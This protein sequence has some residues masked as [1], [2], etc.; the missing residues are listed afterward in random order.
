MSPEHWHYR[1][2]FYAKVLSPTNISFDNGQQSII[3][4]EIKYA[5]AAGIDYFAFDTYCKY[6]KECATNST[7][8]QFYYNTT[9]H[10]YCPEDPTYG[11]DLYLNSQ[12]KDLINFTL[13]LLGSPTCEP[14]NA[15]VYV[16][17]MQ[18][19]TF[20]TVL[21]NRPLVYLFQFKG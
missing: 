4:E 17:L 8:C 2:P 12:Y 1:L 19:D 18:K 11:L 16:D 21:D 20:Q 14:S 10:D 9:S 3:D 7:L 13:V 15:Q 6:G 5:H